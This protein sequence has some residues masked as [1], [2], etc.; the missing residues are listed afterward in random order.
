M[1]MSIMS[2]LAQEESHI[3]SEVMNTSVEMRFKRGIFLTPKL[4]G[5]DLDG[6]GNLII[7][8]NEA[9]IVK[10][11]FF[12]YLYGHSSSEIA[13]ILTGNEIRTPKGNTK[14]SSSTVI[15][16]LRNERHCG[17]VLAR[18]TWTHDYI[19][20]RKRKNK[21]DRNQYKSRD[22]HEAIVSRE[23]FIAVQKL[24]DNAKYGNKG[25]LPELKVITEGTLKGFVTVR[26]K[27]AGFTA[28]DY[29]R[30]SKSVYSDMDNRECKSSSNTESAFDL[31]GYEIA[32]SQFL[33]YRISRPSAYPFRT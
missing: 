10:L 5:Y 31:R 4:F 19:E 11:I 3:K 18:K 32:R 26:C 12:M 27:W 1:T 13:D 28:Q 7:N 29:I 22:H 8:E 30:A 2:V 20:H 25:I 9:K 6:N 14:W 24:I 15:Y 17:D 33:T 21:H 16:I 23:D